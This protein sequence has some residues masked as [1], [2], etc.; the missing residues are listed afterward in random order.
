MRIDLVTLFPQMCEAVLAESIVGRGRKRGAVQVVPHQLRDYAY[1]KHATVDDTVFGGGKGM[2][3][4]AEPIA[5]C[6][7]DLAETLGRKPYTLFMS[8][9]GRPIDQKLLKALCAHENLCVLCGHY[10]GVDQRVL[11][12]YVDEEVSLGDFVLTGGELPA[13]CFIDALARLQPGVLSAD[14]CFEEESHFGGLLEYPQYSRPQV[15]RGRPVPDMLMTGHHAKIAQ[16][17]H[18]QSLLNTL[19]KRPDLLKT[20]P[21]SEK[22]RAFLLENGAGENLFSVET[23]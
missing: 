4:L 10:E 1:D 2:L 18:E 17:R 19:K 13:V 20:A 21:L 14:E 6:F 16:W 8:P 7:D 15:W 23:V 9:Q 11:D 3:L 5:A 12:A 22:D